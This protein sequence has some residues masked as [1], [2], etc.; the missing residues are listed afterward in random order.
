M[1]ARRLG[2]WS[3]AVVLVIGMA[4]VVVLALGMG[5]NGLSEPISDPVLAALCLAGTIGPVVG[6]MRVQLIGVGGYALVLPV[7][8]VLLMR[9]FGHAT[10]AS[11]G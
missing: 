5:L 8:A 1:S 2:F 7:V 4:Y 3:S 10:M 6:N 11:R 9:A